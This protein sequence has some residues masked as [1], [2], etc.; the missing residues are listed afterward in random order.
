[1]GVYNKLCWNLEKSEYSE[2]SYLNDKECVFCERLVDAYLCFTR[3][4]PVDISQ[5]HD[6]P[7]RVGL[8]KAIIIKDVKIVPRRRRTFPEMGHSYFALPPYSQAFFV[9]LW[10]FFSRER[11]TCESFKEMAY[12]VSLKAGLI[13]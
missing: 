7:L 5:P 10:S 1:M 13:S 11:F 6:K 2:N 9:R 8:Q 3:R 4:A 12:W